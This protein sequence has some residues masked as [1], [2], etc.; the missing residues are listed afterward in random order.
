M[1]S[2]FQIDFLW[3]RLCFLVFARSSGPL[4]G[5]NGLKVPVN[6]APKSVRRLSHGLQGSQTSL[7]QY[8][9]QIGE[10]FH[11]NHNRNKDA[12]GPKMVGPK[13]A[14]LDRNSPDFEPTECPRS[15]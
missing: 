1:I 9:P 14:I 3:K 11:Q 15:G 8:K 5:M 10:V 13:R 7:S 2:A 6:L 12:Y 4:D